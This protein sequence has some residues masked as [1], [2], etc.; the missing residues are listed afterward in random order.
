MALTLTPYTDD[1]DYL[2]GRTLLRSSRFLG[3][4][5]YPTG[6]Y[7][8]IKSRFG[9]Q[10]IKQVIGQTPLTD[11]ASEYFLRYDFTDDKVL[12][13]L[14]DNGEQVADTTSVSDCDFK[15]TVIGY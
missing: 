15:L 2:G 5:S 14:T 8:S 9:L 11:A 3:D 12:V 6:G 4:T 13:Y 1:D 7:G 10:E